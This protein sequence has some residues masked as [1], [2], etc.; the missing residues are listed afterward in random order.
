V[1]DMKI[2]DRKTTTKLR[3]RRR[4]GGNR[5]VK[6]VY[7]RSRRVTIRMGEMMRDRAI[8]VATTIITIT[9]T[10]TLI[11]TAT[12]T[13]TTEARATRKRHADGLQTGDMTTLVIRKRRTG[14]CTRL[15]TWIDDIGRKGGYLPEQNRPAGVRE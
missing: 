9:I 13:A 1:E 8:T 12:V 10:I 3:R 5:A 6:K 4:K 2:V 7:R 11:V 14:D 15:T